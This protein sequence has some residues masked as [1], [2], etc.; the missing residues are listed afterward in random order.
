MASLYGGIMVIVHV[1]MLVFGRVYGTLVFR[2]GK[3]LETV[4]VEV[5]EKGYIQFG[6][7]VIDSD[8][9]NKENE[10]SKF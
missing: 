1:V 2:R 6:E 8:I 5:T 10:I 4:D 9:M 7:D 3:K